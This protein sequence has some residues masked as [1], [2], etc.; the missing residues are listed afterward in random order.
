MRHL[1]LRAVAL[2]LTL[3]VA[4]AWPASAAGQ[5]VSGR[6]GTIDQRNTTTRPNS[7]SGFSFVGA[8][9]AAG[10]PQKDPPYMRRMTFYQPRGMRYDTS[11]PGRCTASDLQLEEFGRAAC[12]PASRLGGG[13][14]KGLWMGRIRSTFQMDMFNNAGEQVVVARTPYIATVIRG[15]FSRDQSSVEWSSPTC[16]P[17]PPTGCPVD[18]ALQLGAIQKVPPYTRRVRGVVR[19]YMTTPP[20]C[21][22]A[23]YWK[24]PVRLWWADGTTDTMITKQRCTRSRRKALGR[25]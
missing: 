4:A 6:H 15:R 23:G 17:T 19:S 16:W 12:P 25:A 9:H 10:N 1:S 3:G 18:N 5:P 11:V 20:S 21:P 2:V 24:T 13:Q 14:I 22:A 7:P 8:Y